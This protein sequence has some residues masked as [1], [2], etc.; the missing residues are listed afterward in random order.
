MQRDNLVLCF[1]LNLQSMTTISQQ[2][3]MELR[4]RLSGKRFI[5]GADE[6]L[7]ASVELE[8]AIHQFAVS[9]VS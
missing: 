5:V 8:R 1:S 9:L 2:S 4:L 6:K 7:T 3:R